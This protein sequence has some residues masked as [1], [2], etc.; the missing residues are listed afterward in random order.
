MQKDSVEGRNSF[1]A[2]FLYV[3]TKI[4]NNAKL[5]FSCNSFGTWRTMTEKAKLHNK[6]NKVS[7]SQ[8]S[9]RVRCN[10]FY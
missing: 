9:K 6:T 1:Y 4:A 5:P 7:V 8:N 3:K 2:V 10:P